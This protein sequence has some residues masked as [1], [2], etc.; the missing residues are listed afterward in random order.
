[1]P[2]VYLFKNH[3]GKIIYV[4][5]ANSLRD[6]VGSYFHGKLLPKTER[7]V[8]EITKID[9]ILVESE[10][11]ALLLEAN[12]IRKYCPH[13]NVSWKDGK[14]YPLIE[15]TVKDPIPQVRAVH[16]E[17]NPQALYFGPYPTGS[18]LTSLLRFL[19]RLFPFVSQ[20]HRSGQRCLRSHLGL[21]PCPDYK[22]YRRTLRELVLFL[23]GKRQVVQ[24]QLTAAMTKASAAQNFETAAALKA[25]LTQLAYVTAGR[26]RPWEYQA[27]PN[28]AIDRRQAEI[29]DLQRLLDLPRLHVIECY[30]ISATFGT[31]ATGA[32][33][34][35][36]DGL[37][38]KR[39]YRRYRI[40]NAGAD[41]DMIKEV[42]ARRVKSKTPLPDLI[43]I[44][45]GKEHLV[46]MSI[47]VIGLA[48]NLE[49]IYFG[50]QV[51]QLPA[52]S[53]ALHLVQRL[54]DEAHR[55]SRVY[56]FLLRRQKM[57]T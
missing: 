49:T 32:Q 15:I 16:Q 37:P 4:G 9:Y 51:L 40:K 52:A 12:L 24:K 26:T 38:E 19:R 8:G 30:D 48:K 29:N 35:F 57:L 25:K 56:H 43:V 18:D 6:R 13:Y 27:N 45:G 21:C 28:L 39:L 10:I 44:D 23:S 53:P 11:D 50:D 54:R 2:G 3:A 1:M 20:T 55:F 47:P 14:A 22:N 31:L 34:T 33:V 5:K 17:R 7:L 36:V 41:T 42:L 46:P